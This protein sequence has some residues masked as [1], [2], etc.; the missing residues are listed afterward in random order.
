MMLAITILLAG[1]G[2]GT[3]ESQLAKASLS[4]GTGPYGETPDPELEDGPGRDPWQ[5]ERREP[6]LIDDDLDLP[7]GVVH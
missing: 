5:M 3:S 2:I 6:G 7:D 4:A 1:C